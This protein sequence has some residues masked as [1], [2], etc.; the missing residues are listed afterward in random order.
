MKNKRYKVKSGHKG[1]QFFVVQLNGKKDELIVS[2]HYNKQDAE[3]KHH[4][5]LNP[6]NMK[7]IIYE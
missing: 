7:T 3:Q 2:V 6:P 5:L 1:D 4:E